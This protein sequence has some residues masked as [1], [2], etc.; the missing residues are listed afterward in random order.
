MPSPIYY[1]KRKFNRS[2][3]QDTTMFTKSTIALSFAAILSAASVPLSTHA[4]AE[5]SHLDWNWYGTTSKKGTQMNLY[6]S[7]NAIRGEQSRH[8]GSPL[9]WIDNPASPGG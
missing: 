2:T 8:Q 7:G 1:A 5:N 4:F 6:H 9:R 3:E